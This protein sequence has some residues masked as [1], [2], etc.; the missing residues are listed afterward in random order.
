MT[1]AAPPR[2]GVCALNLPK[3]AGFSHILACF[4]GRQMS[5]SP[6][7]RRDEFGWPLP[8]FMLGPIEALLEPQ[9][10]AP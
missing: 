3:L 2:A 7:P 6:G 8:V 4:F 9:E 1:P 5:Y 10:H